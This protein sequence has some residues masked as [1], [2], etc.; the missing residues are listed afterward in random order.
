MELPHAILDTNLFVSYLL[1]RAAVSSTVSRIL[2]AAL[3]GDFQLVMPEEQ[4]IEFK[5][6]RTKPFLV[7]RISPAEWL[8][9]RNSFRSV[10]LVV[11]KSTEPFPRLVR[12]SS[13]DYLVAVALR[14]EI[15]IVVSGDKDVLALADAFDR[16]I[17]VSPA[18]FVAGWLELD[19]QAS[20]SP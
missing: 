9:L 2:A 5:R 14:H 17:I 1:G 19:D 16:P 13:D 10:A 7:E 11:P 15:D 3:R 12:D 6:I 8:T 18:A 20:G 4:F